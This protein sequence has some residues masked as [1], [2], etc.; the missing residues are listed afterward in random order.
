MMILRAGIE[1][2]FMGVWLR[3]RAVGVKAKADRA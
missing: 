3:D 2:S 1:G